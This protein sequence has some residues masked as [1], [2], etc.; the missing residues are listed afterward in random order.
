MK[1]LQTFITITTQQNVKGSIKR[2]DEVIT[3]VNG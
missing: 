2:L 1:I 3:E